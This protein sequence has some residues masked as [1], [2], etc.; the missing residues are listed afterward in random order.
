MN[1]LYHM[2]NRI[3]LLKQRSRRC[4]CSYCGGSLK[5]QQI[6]FHDIAEVRVELF[7]EQCNR[8]EFGVE[9]EIY[10]SAS[11]F[12]ER[13]EFNF[14]DEMDQNEKTKKMNIA[15]AC[16]LLS[17]GCRYMGFIDDNGFCVSG[18]GQ[19]RNYEEMLVM[20]S[21]EITET[22]TFESWM[23]EYFGNSIKN[24]GTEL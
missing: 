23:E 21:D 15:K 11:S 7:C 19:K 17:W 24:E 5:L 8:I 1:S 18:N 13:T 4:V 2:E 9:P 20:C 16:E 6:M 14:Y 3:E 10:A 12:I 22:P